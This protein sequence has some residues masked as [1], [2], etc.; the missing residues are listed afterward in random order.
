MG[1]YGGATEFVWPDKQVHF[2]KV[3]KAE[4]YALRNLLSPKNF[5]KMKILPW[6]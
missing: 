6:K 5:K 3:L 1:P 4:L 2:K